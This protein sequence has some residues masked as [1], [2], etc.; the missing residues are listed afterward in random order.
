[1]FIRGMFLVFFFQA[2]DGI[3]DRDVTGVQTC[4]LP[5]WPGGDE[6]KQRPR[7]GLEP[8]CENIEKVLVR[9]VQILNEENGRLPR[10]EL[11]EELAPGG[12]KAVARRERVQVRRGFEAEGQAEDRASAKPSLDC[13]GRIAVQQPQMLAHD[14]A[15][16]AVRI[17]PAVGEAASDPVERLGRLCPEPVAELADEPALADPRLTDDHHESRPTLA[18]NAYVRLVKDCQL[19]L[20]PDEAGL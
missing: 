15:Q 16:R 13:L 11:C 3:R 17:P 5:I 7:D 14:L 9:P 8:A 1:M 18:G 4:A 19:R 2:E 20:A 12:L 6:E 10:D